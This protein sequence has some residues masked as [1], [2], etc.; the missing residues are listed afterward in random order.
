MDT[1]A[2]GVVPS[3]T[4]ESVSRVVTTATSAANLFE[5]SANITVINVEELAVAEDII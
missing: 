2:T 5:R 3:T 4:S 1:S